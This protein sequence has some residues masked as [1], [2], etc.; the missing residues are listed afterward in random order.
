MIYSVPYIYPAPGSYEPE[1]VNHEHSPAYSFGSRTNHEKPSE[2]PG[3]DA[4]A[5]IK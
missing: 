1:K 4:M 5:I 3:T 2:T